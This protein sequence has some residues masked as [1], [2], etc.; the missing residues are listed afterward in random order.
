MTFVCGMWIA[1][2]STSQTEV[3][4]QVLGI[5]IVIS[6]CQDLHCL[7]IYATQLRH[8]NYFQEDSEHIKHNHG[9]HIY[10]Q[11]CLLVSDVYL[12]VCFLVSDKASPVM[13]FWV[14]P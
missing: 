12:H 5:G 14:H 4:L 3:C 10:L 7:R 9:V 8:R 11:V 13:L 1:S 6:E 2:E